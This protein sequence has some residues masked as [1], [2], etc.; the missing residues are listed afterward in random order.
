MIPM[1][2]SASCLISSLLWPDLIISGHIDGTIC[3]W[4]GIDGFCE[5]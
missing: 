4:N 5:K 2:N 3:I 1:K